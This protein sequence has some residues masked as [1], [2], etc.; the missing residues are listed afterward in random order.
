MANKTAG[1]NKLI[2]TL[3]QVG[4]ILLV[5]AL[6][7]ISLES[8]L[9]GAIRLIANGDREELEKFLLGFNDFKGY[10]IGFMMQF[11]QIITIVLP[12]IP[13]QIACGIV[14]GL[15]RGFAVCF[16]GYVSAS[17]LIFI[18]SRKLGDKLEKIFPTKPTSERNTAKKNAILDSKHPGFMVF[19]A[20]TFPLLP[21]GLI[22]Y[23]AAKTKIKFPVFLLAI[24]VGCIPTIFTLCAVGKQLINGD[25]LS[26]ALFTLPLIAIF[27]IMFLFQKQ[28]TS[29]YEKIVDRIKNKRK[30][31]EREEDAPE[32]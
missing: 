4:L 26:A 10:V 32:R 14:F 3:I 1:K 27:L 28:I 5:L 19:M 8:V 11:V 22:P 16:L 21:N 6:V 24:G 2:K 15:W 17:A 20:T 25:I 29:C 12:S 13:I 30:T 9:P 7:Y 18:A 31:A 23:I